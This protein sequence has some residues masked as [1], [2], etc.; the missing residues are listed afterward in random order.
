MVPLTGIKEFESRPEHK[1]LVPFRGSFKVAR[2]SIFVGAPSNFDPLSHK[3]PCF[4]YTHPVLKIVLFIK[5]GSKAY[6]ALKKLLLFQKLLYKLS[7]RYCILQRKSNCLGKTFIRSTYDQ[8]GILIITSSL[9]KATKN[10]FF[11]QKF[12]HKH[13]G[14]KNV[15]CRTLIL[16]IQSKQYP[17]IKNTLNYFVN[18]IS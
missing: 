2:N 15:C 1:I 8:N 10:I 6:T 11:D 3:H 13:S 5:D 17:P 14:I 12:E 9:Y 16:K 4:F 18:E 7:R